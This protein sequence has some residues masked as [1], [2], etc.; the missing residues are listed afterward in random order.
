MTRASSGIV[1]RSTSPHSSLTAAKAILDTAFPPRI[2]L[3]PMRYLRRTGV[4]GTTFTARIV[5]Y[6][7]A[8]IAEDLTD[9][10]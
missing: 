10:T 4:L 7:D 6:P 1:P 2:D 5:T 3:V 8:D 9:S